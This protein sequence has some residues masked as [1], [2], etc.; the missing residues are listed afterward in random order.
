MYFQ[1]SKKNTRTYDNSSLGNAWLALSCLRACGVPLWPTRTYYCV[2]FAALSRADWRLFCCAC[3]TYMLW[4][5]EVGLVPLWCA[6]KKSRWCKKVNSVVVCLE[7]MIQLLSFGS[8]S[9]KSTSP[10][11]MFTSR[12]VLPS[13]MTWT[14]KSVCVA[15]LPRSHKHTRARFL[16]L[17]LWCCCIAVGCGAATILLPSLV[18][19]RHL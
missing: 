4:I 2:Y 15:N 16:L 9:K 13:G 18:L 8:L 6:Q 1:F 7:L 10:A 5:S 3:G 12:L 14:E 17:L 11:V 19:S